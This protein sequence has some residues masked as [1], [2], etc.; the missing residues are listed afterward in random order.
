MLEILEMVLIVIAVGVFLYI[1]KDFFKTAKTEQKQ[2]E[3][4]EAV[5][6]ITQAN[7]IG[8]KK[9]KLISYKEALEASRQFI[10]TIAKT[11]MQR[12]SPS[13]KETLL[14][15]GTRL[16]NAG[17]QYIH[18]VDIFKISFERQKARVTRVTKKDDK[19]KRQQ[20]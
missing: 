10:Y 5:E 13:S 6:N 2:T 19:V 17:V 9:F 12:F 18:V 14:E 20:M 1:C 4:A 8:T 3:G 11:V 16:F 7:L 15:L